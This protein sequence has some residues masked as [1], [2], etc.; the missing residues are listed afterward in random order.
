[1]KLRQTT[2]ANIENAEDQAVI[3]FANECL[4]VCEDSLRTFGNE[5]KDMLDSDRH[6]E[7]IDNYIK[8]FVSFL[9]ETLKDIRA[10][11]A[12]MDTTM[13]ET[14]PTFG[15]AFFQSAVKDGEC[16]IQKDMH[17]GKILGANIPLLVTQY[18]KLLGFLNVQVWMADGDEAEHLCLATKRDE[19]QACL[20]LLP[21]AKALG[22]AQVAMEEVQATPS[23]EGAVA[24][25]A[26]FLS[27]FA[28]A[29]HGK[30]NQHHQGCR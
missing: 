25:E 28:A 22:E 11:V 7:P 5:L 12:S 17:L 26:M 4:G 14:N 20:T 9:A 6:K 21:A 23:G 8:S 19:A 1:M 24:K 2:W 18:D 27:K 13:C 10:H 3:A 30:Q 15:L 16:L 29:V